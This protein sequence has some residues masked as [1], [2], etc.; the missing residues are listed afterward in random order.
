MESLNDVW[1]AI[2]EYCKTQISEV[3]FN[4]W[5]GVL[6]P[7]RF[8][9][10]EIVLSVRTSFQKGIIEENYTK[11]LL[12]A[13]QELFGFPVKIVIV[14]EE[15]NPSIG[16]AGAET[17]SKN[18]DA[19]ADYDYTFDTFIVGPSNRFAHAASMAVAENPSVA[20][21]PLFLYGNSGLGKTHLLGAIC[22]RIHE[23]FPEKNTVSIRAGDF[24]IGVINSIRQMTI[25]S[26]REQ[27]LNADVFL[28]DDIHFIA[29][30]ESTQ[31]EF[32]N[33]FNTLYHA[34]KQMVFTSDRPPK[35]IQTLDERIR[36]RFESGLIAD[37]QP[38]EF[39]TR[40][41]IIQR[42]A[43]S[44]RLDLPENVVFYIAEQLKTNIRQLEGVV[45]KMQ[46][47]SMMGEAPSMAV[48]Q[49]SIRDVRNDDQP[50]PVTIDRILS[51]VSRTYGVSPEDI[52]SKKRDAPISAARQVAMYIVREVTQMPVQAVGAHFGGRDHTTVLYAIGQVEKKMQKNPK[53]RALIQD[54]LKN[55]QT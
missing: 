25:S 21:N 15:E 55:V 41:S 5:I 27:F 8:S 4:V 37:I 50:E 7:I 30:K 12:S 22:N 24:T 26:Y 19:M 13:F 39:E 20:Y 42:K 52:C 40:V 2:C 45:K 6:N 46:A 14:S 31:E 9:D 3:A 51:E 17:L 34:R 33:V 49:I 18:N 32:F 38:P 23:K 29:G 48:A 28:V 47:Y 35:E 11:L 10:G 53:E 1:E 44:M 36:S 54:I 43:K 16:N